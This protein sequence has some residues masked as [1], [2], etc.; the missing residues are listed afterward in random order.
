MNDYDLRVTNNPEGKCY[1]LTLFSLKD[2]LPVLYVT[3]MYQDCL[4]GEIESEEFLLKGIISFYEKNKKSI[5][6]GMPINGKIIF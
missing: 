5:E 6:G 1:D 2:N 3:R 4:N